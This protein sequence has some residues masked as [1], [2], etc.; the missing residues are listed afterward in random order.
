M[1]HARHDPSEQAAYDVASLVQEDTPMA[2]GCFRAA[3]GI[4]RSEIDRKLFG[5]AS[6]Q[7]GAMSRWE[8]LKCPS[9]AVPGLSFGAAEAARMLSASASGA[10]A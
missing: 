1:L 3:V 4:V 10:R 7:A 6:E 9:S 5:D 2:S 8:A